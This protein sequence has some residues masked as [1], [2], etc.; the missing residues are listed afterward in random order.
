M[1][2]K[3]LLQGSLGEENGQDQHDQLNDR[4]EEANDPQSVLL[5]LIEGQMKKHRG[6]QQNPAN[7]PPEPSAKSMGEL[8]GI[9]VHHRTGCAIPQPSV[10]T[11]GTAL[12]HE[13]PA[14]HHQQRNKQITYQYKPPRSSWGRMQSSKRSKA[15][16]RSKVCG[17]GGLY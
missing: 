4:A 14:N 10:D 8:P 12:P 11:L 17:F 7:P 15:C 3:R 16:R 1:I 6:D 2:R 5:A 9:H 13:D